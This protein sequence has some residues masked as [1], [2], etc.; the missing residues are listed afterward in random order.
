MTSVGYKHIPGGQ[1]VGNSLSTW[2][3]L[4][5]SAP[6]AVRRYEVCSRSKRPL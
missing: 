4:D 5:I 1:K 2:S 3:A 6:Q